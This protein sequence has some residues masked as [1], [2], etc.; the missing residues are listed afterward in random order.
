M[1]CICLLCLSVSLC[2]QTVDL[3]HLGTGTVSLAGQWKFHPG[4]NPQWAD[5]NFDDS[6]WKFVKVPLSLQKQGYL[7]FSGYGWYR[8]TLYCNSHAAVPDLRLAVSGVSDV[9]AFFANDVQFGQFGEFPPKARLFLPRPMSFPISS[10]HW[11]NSRLLLAVRIWV[12]PNIAAWGK[13]GFDNNLG[14]ELPPLTIGSPAAIQN[15][16]DA[17]KRDRELNRLPVML[18]KFAGFILALYLL[19]LYFTESQRPEYFWL[20]LNFAGDALIELIQWIAQ[21]TFLLSAYNFSFLNCLITPFLFT[22]VIFGIWS[23]FNVQVGRP[24]R[25]FLSFLLIYYLAFY[26]AIEF[27]FLATWQK[28][29]FLQF[30]VFPVGICIILFFLLRRSWTSSGELRWFALSYVPSSAILLIRYSAALISAVGKH[31]NSDLIE[32]LFTTTSTFT[33]IAVGFLLM[34]RSG[35]A[36]AEQD[37]LHAEMRAAQ[38]V[39]KLMLP[40]QSVDAP[41]VHI[42]TAYLPS[43]EVGGDFYQIATS[44]DGALLLIIGDVSGKGLQA[45]LT[46]SLIV[47][48]W[49][50]VVATVQSPCE[51]LCRFNRYL[52][53]RM[54]GGFVTCLCARLQPDGQLLIAN[55]GHLAPYLN[56]KELAILNG[57]PLGISAESDYGESHFLLAPTDTLI[58]ISDGVVEA[59]DKSHSFYGFER[60]Q[61]ALSERPGAEVIARRA[62]QFGQEDDITVIAISPRVVTTGLTTAQAA[63]AE[64]V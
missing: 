63:L 38:Q 58:L 45:A 40:A 13:G 24:L 51:I 22:T 5:P 29:D 18:T 12:D 47:G 35:R 42:D 27:G 49:Q 21:D 28:Y 53:R 43:Q 54:S 33:V 1:R 34:R 15:L 64:H 44:D 25:M 11:Q 55:A 37:R 60:L 62:Q 48:L 14:A 39:Q 16:V 61:Q 30:I 46:M 4:D 20:G 36:R 6:A 7:N 56:G 2:A 9:G 57:L 17:S 31:I 59:R 41:H 19:G 50:E 10:S 52:Q 23:V 26:A 3:S 8:L 32:F